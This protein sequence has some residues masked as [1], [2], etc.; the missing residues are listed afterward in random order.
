MSAPFF[1]LALLKAS[2]APLQASGLVREIAVLGSA[3]RANPERAIRPQPSLVLV[4]EGTECAGPAGLGNGRFVRESLAV[5][6]QVRH[7]RSDDAAAGADLTA[8]RSAVWEILEGNRLALT[9]APLRYD[10]G[11]LL[12]ID[13]TLFTWL[14]RYSTETAA[15]TRPRP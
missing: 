1:P 15:P 7:S 8:L 9:W 14:D 13:E 11:Q 12:S 4:T 3:E 6:I 2:L 10:G 5:V